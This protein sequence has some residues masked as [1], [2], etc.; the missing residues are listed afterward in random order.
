[1]IRIGICD[2]SPAFLG[3][4]KFMIDHW[5]GRPQNIITELF[6]DGDAL[7]KAHAQ[8][9]FD[10]LLLDVVMPL[11]SGIDAAKEIRD[12]DKTVK[13]VFLTSSAEFAV[14]SYTVKASNYLLKPIEPSRL[15]VCLDEL[16]EE[17]GHHS[18]CLTVKGL[19]AIHR[20]P[21]TDI[22]YV[23]AQSKHIRFY[24]TS[25]KVI[26]SVEPL[27]AYENVLTSEDG[28][29][30]CHRS[31]I[32]NMH[33]INRYSHT[34]AVMHSGYR[35]PISRSHQKTFEDVYFR[36]VFEKAGDNL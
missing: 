20:I 7:I 23:E 17:I 35:I 32:V 19:D 28:F 21:L 11:L 4:T 34:E 3:Q 1:M 26:E 6:E 22:A 29:F 12:K 15:F 31:Y 9:P 30:K 8:A 18:K 16:I 36:V 10:I 5:D 2:D 13:I 33:H 27:Y 25:N 14:D 24:L